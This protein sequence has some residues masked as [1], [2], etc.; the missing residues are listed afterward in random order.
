V[1]VGKLDSL[2]LPEKNLTCGEHAYKGVYVLSRDPL[3]VYIEGFL[4]EGEGKEV[5]RLR[6]VE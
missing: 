3:V 4:S 5:V 2:V 1:D 6:Y